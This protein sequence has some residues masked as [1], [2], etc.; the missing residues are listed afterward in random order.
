MALNKKPASDDWVPEP[1][2]TDK[3]L[4]PVAELMAHVQIAARVIK[5]EGEVVTLGVPCIPLNEA[6]REALRRLFP[7]TQGHAERLL[8]IE[9][10]IAAWESPRK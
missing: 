7:Y 5:V 8:D 10:L 3:D 6:D 9:A 2:P 4:R 1:H